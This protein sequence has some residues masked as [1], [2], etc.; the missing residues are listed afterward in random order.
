L[1]DVATRV[2]YS[3]AQIGDFAAN[4]VVEDEGAQAAAE[5]PEVGYI[6]GLQLRYP[7]PDVVADLRDQFRKDRRVAVS[8]DRAGRLVRQYAIAL[9]AESADREANALNRG[10][11][12]ADEDYRGGGR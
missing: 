2:K 10:I 12:R 6:L 11:E 1:S 8:K 7:R 5:E 3:P 4:A 9:P